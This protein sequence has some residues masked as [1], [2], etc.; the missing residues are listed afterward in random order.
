ME[1]V[2]SPVAYATNGALI[3]FGM[4]LSDWA[5]AIGILLGV[6]TFALNWYF[7]AKRLSRNA[8]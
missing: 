5:A 8:D 6:A 2:T 3:V 1:R 4:T 7:Q